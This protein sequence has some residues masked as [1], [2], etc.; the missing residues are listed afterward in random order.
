MNCPL[1]KGTQ[2][3]HY[4]MTTILVITCHFLWKMMVMSHHH[5]LPLKIMILQITL[6]ALWKHCNCLLLSDGMVKSS[7]LVLHDAVRNSKQLEV[8]QIASMVIAHQLTSSMM[9]CA[10]EQTINWVAPMLHLICQT[11]VQFP[12]LVDRKSVV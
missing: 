7:Q 4:P 1:R 2:M 3:I 6:H 10:G 8:N 11:Q 5:L 12:D 9:I